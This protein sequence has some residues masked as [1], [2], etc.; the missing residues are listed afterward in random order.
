MTEAMR[1]LVSVIIPVYNGSEYLKEAI[2][3]ALGQ[4]YSRI[5]VIVIN[6]GSKDEGKT[7]SLALSYSDRIRYVK[8]ENGGVAS[9]LNRGI[10][11]AK[12]EYISWLSHDD[13]YEY[14]KIRDQMSFMESLPP[15]ER[16]KTIIY[17]N[18]LFMN[19]RSEVYDRSNLPRVRPDGFYEALL[20]GRVIHNLWDQE[21]F[22]M[23]GCTA[24]FPRSVLFDA[25]LFDERRR[26]TQDYDLWFKLCGTHEFVLSD[27]LVLRSR[28]HKGQGTYLLRDSMSKEVD[29]LYSSALDLYRPGST[30]YDLD[31]AKTAFALRLDPRRKKAFW[32]AWRMA[33]LQPPRPSGLVYLALALFWNS[34]LAKARIS[35]NSLSRRRKERK[36]P[37]KT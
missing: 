3:S 33:V 21:Y 5:E 31:L 10:V 36:A 14:D 2:D 1:P 6:D 32:K 7:E 37:K 8:K 13:A 20:G 19:E 4:S 35:L 16:M 15:T 9:A 27:A 12:G 25:G 17:G 34:W 11:E 23:N 24:L 26:T 28:I 22:F 18:C 29:E 30:R